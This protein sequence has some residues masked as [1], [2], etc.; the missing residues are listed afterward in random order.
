MRLLDRYLLLQVLVPFLYCAGGFTAVFILFDMTGT[1][2]KLF[3]EGGGLGSAVRFYWTQ[4]PYMLMLFLPA[5]LLLGSIFSLGKLSRTNELSAIQGA[6][7]PFVRMLAPVLLLGVVVSAASTFLSYDWATELDAQKQ[8]ILNQVVGKATPQFAMT[9]H[10]FRNRQDHRTWFVEELPLEGN[11]LHGVE[12]TQ[13]RAD[14]TPE[15]KVYAGRAIYE[16][17]TGQW[18]FLDTKLVRY[19]PDGIVVQQRILPAHTVDGWTETPW[20]LVSS[21]Y[22]ARY[23]GATNLRRYLQENADFPEHQLA[24][25]R[26]YLFYRWAQPWACLVAVLIAAPLGVARGRRGMF[27]NLGMALGLFF[28]HVLL[29]NVFLALGEGSRIPAWLA[30]WGP[31]VLIGGIGIFMLWWR[32][33]NREWSMLFSRQPAPVSPGEN[34]LSPS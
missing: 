14:G 26:T 30:A 9:A 27:G 19:R 12:I 4:L 22:K 28:I 13:Q 20:R 7:V 16:P 24:P 10:L 21:A 23:L 3:G 18:R 8:R 2:G 17:L 15:W 25:F 1:S 11:E 32:S 5:A 6:G 33:G 29:T 34:A 31:N